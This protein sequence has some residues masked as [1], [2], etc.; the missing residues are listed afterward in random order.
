MI[1]IEVEYGDGIYKLVQKTRGSSLM[2]LH[3]D[4]ELMGYIRMSEIIKLIESEEKI[5]KI[6]DSKKENVFNKIL[7]PDYDVIDAKWK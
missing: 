1:E 2:E 5:K 4:G 6:E 3:K 7:K